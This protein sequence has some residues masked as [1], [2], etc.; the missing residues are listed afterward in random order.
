MEVIKE[1]YLEKNISTDAFKKQYKKFYFV[2][3]K[4]REN[5]STKTLE[6]FKDNNNWTKKEPKG[7]CNLYSQ[8]NVHIKLKQKRKFIFEIISVDKSHELMT[9][10]ETTGEEWVEL[11]TE[12]LAIETFNV[13]LM[14]YPKAA[15]NYVKDMK[16]TVQLKIDDSSVTLL[17]NNG[18]AVYWRF[19]I[20]R[21]YKMNNGLV[22][23]EVG[24]KSITGEGEFY[25]DTTDPKRLYDILDRAV[26]ER[27]KKRGIVPNT[28]AKGNCP[29]VEKRMNSHLVDNRFNTNKAGNAEPNDSAYDHLSHVANHLA[30]PS[31]PPPN[32]GNTYDSLFSTTRMVT[33]RRSEPQIAPFLNNTKLLNGKTKITSSAGTPPATPTISEDMYVQMDSS[34]TSE[35]KKPIPPPL[36]TKPAT[37]LRSMGRSLDLETHPNDKRPVGKL[38]NPPLRPKEEFA[39]GLNP[40]KKSTSTSDIC[41][42]SNNTYDVPKELSKSSNS[43]NKENQN[44]PTDEYNHLFEHPLKEVPKELSEYNHLT[45]NSPPKP[46]TRPNKLALNLKQE[47]KTATNKI[48]LS[49]VS[50]VKEKKKPLRP[51]RP[52]P[53]APPLQKQQPVYD[54][55]KSKISTLDYRDAGYNQV[56]DVILGEYQANITDTDGYIEIPSSLK[57]H[58]IYDIPRE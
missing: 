4:D 48:Q 12:G 47:L 18:P 38:I 44:S 51:A 8:Y 22:I 52:A 29:L 56:G 33:Q 5:S 46:L 57:S 25:F 54:I 27:V 2:L 43:D 14:R 36:R 39:G 13:I 45:H 50:P 34:P 41:D 24:K 26:R 49:P 7:V 6:Y 31:T 37:A 17:S 55:P 35:S 28:N 30:K 19:S 53:L 23:L 11:L 9:T 21:K 10:D 1:G 40:K 3:K 20:I 32:S 15:E 42:D 58:S 16:G